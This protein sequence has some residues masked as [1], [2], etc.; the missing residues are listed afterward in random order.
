MGTMESFVEV[1]QIEGAHGTQLVR[2]W[3]ETV[4]VN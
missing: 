1:H 3:V 2:V 4:A